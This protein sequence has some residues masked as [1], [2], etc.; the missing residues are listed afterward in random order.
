LDSK[1][2]PNKRILLNGDILAFYGILK[3]GIASTAE[4]ELGVSFMNCTKK[5]NMCA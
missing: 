3:F 1:L 4:E 5:E 2:L